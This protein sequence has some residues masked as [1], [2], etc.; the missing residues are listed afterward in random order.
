MILEDNIG[1]FEVGCAVL[2]KDRLITGEVD[3][4]ELAGGFLTS[5]KN[6]P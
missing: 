3:E 5:R 2:G 1:G 4:I 6:I